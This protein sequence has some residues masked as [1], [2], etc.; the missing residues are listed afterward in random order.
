MSIH[1]HIV[2]FTLYIALSGRGQSLPCNPAATKETKQLY[3]NMQDLAGK[4]VLFGH[5]DALAYGVGWAYQPGQS[6]VK[7]ITG[8]HPALFGWELGN[9]ELGHTKNLDSVPFDAMKAF[10]KEGYAMDGVITI[11]WHT[12][13]PLT[14]KSA[15]DPTPGTVTSVLPGGAKHVIM[16]QWLQ[17]VADFLESLKDDK[18]NPIPIL[19]RPWHEL[20][21]NWFWWCQHGSTPDEFKTLWKMTYDYMVHTRKL[22]HLLWVY[23]TSSFSTKEHFLERYPGNDFADFISYDDYQHENQIKNEQNDFVKKNQQMLSIMQE[24]SGNIKKPMA[25]AETGFETIP[26]SNWWTNDLLPLLTTYPVSYVM[27]WRNAGKMPGKEK[28]HYYVPFPGDI[29][30]NDFLHFSKHPAIRLS[31]NVK[32]NILYKQK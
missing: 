18:G 22:N 23:N 17:R 16:M 29:S 28:M 31:N 30:A 25:I 2:F 4:A 11:S 9:L 12:N 10:I 15:W 19:F 3:Q 20:T 27:L 8:H 14:G 7:K 24:I 6:D 5:Q 13:N 1:L 32:G 21:G 26:K